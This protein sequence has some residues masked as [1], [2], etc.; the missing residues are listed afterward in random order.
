MVKVGFRAFLQTDSTYESYSRPDFTPSISNAKT[1]TPNLCLNS[2]TR[3][4]VFP[5]DSLTKKKMN[6]VKK[7][8]DSY[9][10]VFVEK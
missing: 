9:F 7:V 10:S 4:Q 5:Q 2:R 8:S 6:M 1:L 3:S